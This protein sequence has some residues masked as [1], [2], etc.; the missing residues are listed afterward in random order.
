LRALGE[1]KAREASGLELIP[2]LVGN[3]IYREG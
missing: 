3:P 1:D 2:G